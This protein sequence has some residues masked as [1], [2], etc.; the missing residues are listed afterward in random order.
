MKHPSELPDSI[1]NT[2]AA[3]QPTKR[4]GDPTLLSD[5]AFCRL[6]FIGK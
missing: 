4:T 5:T 6:I 2:S 1:G 3:I